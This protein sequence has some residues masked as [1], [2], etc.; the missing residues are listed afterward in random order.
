MQDKTA[1]KKQTKRSRF[2]DIT[3]GSQKTAADEQT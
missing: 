3:Q 1:K 2:W